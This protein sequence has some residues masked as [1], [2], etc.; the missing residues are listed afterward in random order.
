MKIKINQMAGGLK[1]FAVVLAALALPAKAAIIYSFGS[2]VNTFSITFNGVN[3]SLEMGRTEILKSDFSSYYYLT[4]NNVYSANV[5]GTASHSQVGIT[6]IQTVGMINWLN[7]SVGLPA[8]YTFSGNGSS[9][10]NWTRNSGAKF[11]LPT[12]QNGAWG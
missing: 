7:T 4:T 6:G 11:F 5:N 1:C 8:A 10:V 3:A 9:L 2:G 12:A